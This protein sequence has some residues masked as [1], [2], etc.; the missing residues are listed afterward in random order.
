MHLKVCIGEITGARIRG[1]R[2][3]V[4]SLQLHMHIISCII[5]IHVFHIRIISESA[6]ITRQIQLHIYRSCYLTGLFLMQHRTKDEQGRHRFVQAAHVSPYDC[7]KP[8][9]SGTTSDADTADFYPHPLPL[10]LPA[11]IS[12]TRTM[13]TVRPRPHHARVASATGYRSCA[14][15]FSPA[16]APG[17]VTNQPTNQRGASA[18]THRRR[19]ARSL[20]GL[21]LRIMDC[22]DIRTWIGNQ[23]L[24]AY[25]LS[26][27]HDPSTH[28]CSCVLLLYL[29]Y[30]I[31]SKLYRFSVYV[32]RI[33]HKP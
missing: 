5:A 24:T 3:Y 32:K 33:C 2:G 4:I 7:S 13:L 27:S 31:V 18:A 20:D 17:D 21:V 16:E 19:R 29:L 15:S 6:S 11:H 10:P 28:Q 25:E 8:P 9:S 14:A 1:S 22:G 30:K 23:Q 26:A 12:T